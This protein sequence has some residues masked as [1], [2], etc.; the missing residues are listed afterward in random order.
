MVS[1]AAGRFCSA[2]MIWLSFVRFWGRRSGVET[3]SI[4]GALELGVLIMSLG[5]VLR[6]NSLQSTL[7]MVLDGNKTADFSLSFS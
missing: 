3:E 4:T 7:A 1:F 5:R 6:E 2:E